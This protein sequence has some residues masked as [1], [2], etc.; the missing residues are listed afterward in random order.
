MK[1]VITLFYKLR[2]HTGCLKMIYTN[3]IKRNLKL[4]MSINNIKLFLDFKESNLNSKPSFAGIH[5]VIREKWHFEHK[6]R[7]R[8]FGQL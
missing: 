8:N 5:E 4:I 7:T 6:C 2:Y 1:E 3:L